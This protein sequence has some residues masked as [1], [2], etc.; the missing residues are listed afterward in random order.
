[1]RA[2]ALVV[3]LVVLGCRGNP[4]DLFFYLG[5]VR[6]GAGNPLSDVQIDVGRTLN[7]R[8]TP[9]VGDS[10][11]IEQQA[12]FEA[13]SSTRSD[14]S[15]RFLI[16]LMRFELE[17]PTR[18]VRCFRVSAEKG[19][20]TAE[21]RFYGVAADQDLPALLLVGADEL[22]VETSAAGW[23]A[24]RPEPL[25]IA[26]EN[27]PGTVY[28]ETTA[29]R[30]DQV[31]YDWSVDSSAGRVWLQRATAAPLEIPTELLEDFSAPTVSLEIVSYVVRQGNPL[32]GVS[33]SSYIGLARSAPRPLGSTGVAAVSRG[34]PCTLNAAAVSP[35][36]ATD[37]TLKGSYLQSQLVPG[38][39]P[40]PTN[41]DLFTVDLG[42]VATPNT[43]ILRDAMIGG[44]VPLAIEVSA[45]GTT[46]TKAA[47]IPPRY[48]M[49]EDPTVYRYSELRYEGVYES[50]RLDAPGG[51]RHLRIVGHEHDRVSLVGDISLVNGR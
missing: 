12:P 32:T 11:F 29:Y 47:E 44:G 27:V 19:G 10:A 23:S 22:G 4:E 28:D 43:L 17:T 26:E 8:C 3:A 2:F 7:G 35:C 1:M 40:P 38:Q 20:A 34:K 37:A 45:D 30:P 6:D 25:P 31:Y 14:G 33:S 5:E 46:W 48:S 13:Y 39:P 18:E 41:G 15:G 16:E 36:P 42:E 49:D 21:L 51:F 9:T 50:H 24:R